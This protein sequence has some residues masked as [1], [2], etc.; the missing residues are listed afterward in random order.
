MHKSAPLKS[1][2]HLK[3]RRKVHQLIEQ[4]HLLDRQSGHRLLGL[5]HESLHVVQNM[6]VI[7]L[8]ACNVYLMGMSCVY[9]LYTRFI[10]CVCSVS[11]YNVY[12]MCV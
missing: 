8:Y 10:S 4:L 7:T 6:C 5:F 2:S 1:P 11:D 9:N 12:T 3:S